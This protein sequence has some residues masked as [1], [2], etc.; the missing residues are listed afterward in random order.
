MKVVVCAKPIRDPE[1]PD[2]GK[3]VLDD[4]DAVGIE[5]GL[6][7]GEVVLAAMAPQE[8]VAA[9][10]TGLA[11]GAERAVLVSDERLAGADALATAKVLA[12]VV[13]R[14]LPVDLVV[15]AS[16]STDG[17]SGV[18]AAQMAELLG[19]PVLTFA[20]RISLTAHEVLVERE[21]ERGYDELACEL[22]CVVSVTAGVATPRY[23]SYK[24][25]V[26]ARTKS[27]EMLTLDDLGFSAAPS[28]GQEVVEVVRP[29]ARRA[30][31]VIEDDGTAHERILDL[32]V[33]LKVV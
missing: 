28:V 17:Y 31:V 7:A 30:G 22:P 14:Q 12:A 10:R 21:T 18:V 4:A 33:R 24:A 11:L 25:I 16:L 26:A 2:S 3:R 32:L 5:V 29:P 9:L 20:R 13:R 8:G 6:R 1:A 23:P 19:L 27:V 15:T